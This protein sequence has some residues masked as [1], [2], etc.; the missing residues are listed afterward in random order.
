MCRRI[1]INLLTIA[2]LVDS[3]NLASLVDSRFIQHTDLCLGLVFRGDVKTTELIVDTNNRSHTHTRLVAEQ[4]HTLRVFLQGIKALFCAFKLCFLL[5]QG[6][7]YRY[8]SCFVLGNTCIDFG[9]SP[10][11]C[12]L[13][14][15]KETAEIHVSPFGIY[16]DVADLGFVG[17]CTVKQSQTSI[18]RQVFRNLIGSTKLESEIVLASLHITVH[19]VASS[20][21]G[22]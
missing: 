9:K 13:C 17:G 19:I 21:E 15:L 1:L 3:G 11:D 18:Y 22:L 2:E 4:V 16:H 5:C 6:I 12:C 7:R 8:S 10:V 14:I 20:T